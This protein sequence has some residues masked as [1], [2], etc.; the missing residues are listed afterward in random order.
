MKSKYDVRAKCPFCDKQMA[1]VKGKMA[2]N[3]RRNHGF[4]VMEYDFYECKNKKCF[5]NRIQ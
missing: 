2:S 4:E 5:M 1:K 3:Y